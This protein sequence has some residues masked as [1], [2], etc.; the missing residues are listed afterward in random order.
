M[1]Y[2]DLCNYYKTAHAKTQG[3]GKC[4]CE[5]TGFVFHIKPEEYNLEKYPCFDYE[6]KTRA[7]ETEELKETMIAN[8]ADRKLA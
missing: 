1:L 8:F 2:C 4:M 6:L 5:L 7:I 3:I